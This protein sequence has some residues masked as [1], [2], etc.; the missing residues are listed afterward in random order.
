MHIEGKHQTLGIFG[1]ANGALTCLIKEGS[2]SILIRGHQRD[3]LKSFECKNA[4]IGPNNH[5]SESTYLSRCRTISPESRRP[6][7]LRDLSDQAVNS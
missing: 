3:R 4:L 7:T 1:Q 2:I 6:N 5:D